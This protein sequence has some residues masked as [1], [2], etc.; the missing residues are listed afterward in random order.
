MSNENPIVP[1]GSER[2]DAVREKA[3]QVKARQARN[4]V[5]ARV[6]IVV[7]ALVAIV[8]IIIAIWLAVSPT[9]NRAQLDPKNFDDG[10]AFEVRQT[11][12]LSSLTQSATPSDAPTASASATPTAAATAQPDSSVVHV[13]VYVDYLA[14]GAADFEKANASQLATW[15]SGGY[16]ELDYHPVALLNEKADGYS[17]RAAAAVACVRSYVPEAALGFSHS[18]LLQQP[19]LDDN[20]YSNDELISIASDAGASSTE[21]SNCIT[22]GDYVKWVRDATKRA[23][24]EPLPGTDGVM[25]TGAPTIVVN[26]QLYTGSRTDPAEFSAFILTVASADYYESASPTPTETSAG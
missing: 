25:L 26:G 15:V 19:T 2:R 11:D 4:R 23:M 21:V 17:L 16:V 6:G 7:A 12:D 20:G 14:E 1:S 13:E 18:L 3:E 8:A 24:E 10:D 22:N 9:V 5:L